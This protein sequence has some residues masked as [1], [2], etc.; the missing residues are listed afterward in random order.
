MRRLLAVLAAVGL[1]VGAVLVRQRIDDGG[2]GGGGDDT[3]RIVCG[4]DLAAA[5]A[6]LAEQDAGIDVTVEDEGVTA[7]RLSALAGDGGADATVDPGFDAW[8]TAGPWPAIVADNRQQTGVDGRVLGRSSAVLGRSA[9]TIVAQQDRA[10]ALTGSCGG[11]VTWACIGDVAGLPWTEA[12]GQ[13]AWGTVKPGL[14]APARGAGL[15]AL[16]Q[17]VASQV[18][19]P[20]W[21]SNDLEEPENS[22]WFDQ[23]VGQAKRARVAGQSPLTRFLVVPASFGAVGALEAESGPAVARAANRSGLEVIYPEP[24]ATADVTLTPSAGGDAADVLDRIDADG[25]GAALAAT[26]WR[27]DGQRNADGVGGGPDLPADDGLP[28]AGALQTLRSRW[29]LVP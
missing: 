4:T 24:V 2:G 22:T 28:S 5:C 25:L 10:K 8:L 18:G 26:G 15:V 19:T 29:D 17:A 20:D 14:A 9:A 3:V 21:A 7:D 11:A 23:L 27:V 1:V 6:R 16:A 12:G 13:A